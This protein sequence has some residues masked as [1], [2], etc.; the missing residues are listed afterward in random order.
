MFRYEPGESLGCC[1]YGICTHWNSRRRTA[2]LLEERNYQTI[3]PLVVMQLA[4]CSLRGKLE[5]SSVA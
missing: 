4:A 2:K 3:E 5:S 1:L